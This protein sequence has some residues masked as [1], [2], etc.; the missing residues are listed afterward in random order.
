MSKKFQWL[1]IAGLLAP[2]A[3]QAQSRVRLRAPVVGL[4]AHR[5]FAFQPRIPARTMV[6]QHAIRRLMAGRQF[7]RGPVRTLGRFVMPRGSVM[8]R[9]RMP[10]RGRIR[11]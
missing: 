9:Y 1:L 3:V 2:V 4:R 11:I 8:L 7:H 5:P 10:G 6:R